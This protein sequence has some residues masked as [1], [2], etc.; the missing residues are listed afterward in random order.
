MSAAAR[1][2][3]HTLSQQLL[4]VCASDGFCSPPLVYLLRIRLDSL[5]VSP[6]LDLSTGPAVLYLSAYQIYSSTVSLNVFVWLQDRISSWQGVLLAVHLYIPA[7]PRVFLT[8]LC[9]SAPNFFS[10]SIPT[11]NPI[12]PWI[13]LQAKSCICHMCGAHLNR[14]HSC[15]YCVFFGCFTKKHIHEHAKNKRHNLGKLHTQSHAVM[16]W[17]YYCLIDDIII[18]V[19]M[20]CLKKLKCKSPA[21][22]HYISLHMYPYILLQNQL[23]SVTNCVIALGNVLLW[24]DRELNIFNCSTLPFCW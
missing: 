17:N 13:F 23:L 21:I 14:L 10:P 2:L 9:F 11:P 24:V 19:N 4:L 3:T 6:A 18:I 20:C 1:Q 8:I 22:S 7:Q 12:L 16:S 5:H 15:L